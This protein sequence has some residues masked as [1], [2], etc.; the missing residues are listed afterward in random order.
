[1]TDLTT[2]RRTRPTSLA[3]VRLALAAGLMLV[4]PLGPAAA[5]TVDY[6]RCLDMAQSDPERARDQAARWAALGGGAPARHCAAIALIGLGADRLAA[7]ELTIIGSTPGEISI[8]DR[9]AALL[10]AGDLWLSLDVTGAA[11]Q[12]YSAAATLAPE[13]PG[14]LIGLA[15]A[16]GAEEDWAGAV[17]RLDQALTVAPRSAEALTLRAAAYRRLGEVIPALQDSTYATELAPRAAL[18][19][20]ERGAAELAVGETRAASESW[21]MASRLDPEGVAGDLAR[22]NLQRLAIGE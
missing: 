11:R 15:R 7:E 19:W 5:Q 6:G 21:L 13:N 4:A 18:A 1:M 16:D 8:D 3:V 12:V 22:T 17:T 10:L 20:F 2:R 14:P 9:V